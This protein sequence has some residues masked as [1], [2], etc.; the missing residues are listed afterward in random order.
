MS[1]P[2]RT[3]FYPAF[4]AA[5][6]PWWH[7]ECWNGPALQLEKF[8]GADGIRVVSSPTVRGIHVAIGFSG[9][10]KLRAV[11]TEIYVQDITA[12]AR[13]HELL[14][15]ID[16]DEPWVRPLW[17]G[18]RDG[19]HRARKA[20]QPDV[21][22]VYAVAGAARVGACLPIPSAGVA[23]FTDPRLGQTPTPVA[24]AVGIERAGTAGRIVTFLDR[25]VDL[26]LAADV[27]RAAVWM[28]STLP[29][30][31]SVLA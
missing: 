1:T 25:P 2:T 14:R 27:E 8:V 15:A 19:V 13:F 22:G 11:K 26:S 21:P 18:V 31:R 16:L 9:Q 28:A 17:A 30:F 24:G 10:G 20:T 3:T 12:N 4:Y 5:F 29:V 7:R 23:A 6:W